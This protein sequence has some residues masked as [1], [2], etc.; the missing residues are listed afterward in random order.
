MINGAFEMKQWILSA[1]YCVF[2]KKSGLE[3]QLKTQTKNITAYEIRQQI[4]PNKTYET[5]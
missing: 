3:I 1:N 2:D 5:Q 4:S